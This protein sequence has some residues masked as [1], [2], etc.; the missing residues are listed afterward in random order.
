MMVQQLSGASGPAAGRGGMNAKQVGLGS[1]ISSIDSI[2]TQGSLQ[3]TA[4]PLDLALSGDGFFAVASIADITR[5]NVDSDT[6]YGDN[7]ILGGAVDNAMSLNYTRSGNFYLD[8]NGYIVNANGMYLIGETGEKKIPND[9]II[10]AS[11]AA[12]NAGEIFFDEYRDFRND[13]NKFLDLAM[14]FLEAQ[15]TYEDAEKLA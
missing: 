3:T 4:R 9:D 2:Q 13:T 5:V 7:R 8:N 12:L 6:M 15:R 1:M 11:N 10:G 14:R